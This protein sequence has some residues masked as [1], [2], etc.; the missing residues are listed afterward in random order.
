M[1]NNLQTIIILVLTA[2]ILWLTQ[3]NRVECPPE[4]DSWVVYQYDTIY[5]P[6]FITELQHDT[7]YIPEILKQDTNAAIVQYIE[8][9]QDIVAEYLSKRYYSDT[10]NVDTLGRI[11][12][13]DVIYKN[14]LL[15]RKVDTDIFFSANVLNKADRVRSNAFYWGFSVL[16]SQQQF[17]A[18]TG[19]IL[20][21]T[22][23]NAYSVGFG[24]DNDAQFIFKGSIYF[25]L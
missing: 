15:T 9:N 19:D 23:R 22:K 12:I 11:I 14:R 5:Q 4:K 10:I 18:L 3:C 20:L 25:K 16:G 1:L 21:T 24:V 13:D 17:N 6:K 2:V 7:V 8:Q